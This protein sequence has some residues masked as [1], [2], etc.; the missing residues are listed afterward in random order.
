MKRFSS[1][2]SLSTLL[3]PRQEKKNPNDNC[4]YSSEKY[5]EMP[6]GLDDED[7][8]TYMEETG[9][10]TDKKRR[11]SYTQV[12]T[13]EKIFEV[14]NKLDPGKK[15]TLA[16]ELG[17]QPR[18]VAIWFQN[19]RA[20]WK[21]KQLERDYNHLKANYESLKLNY[22]KLEQS[23][24]NLIHELRELK[25]KLEKENTETNQPISGLQTNG[26]SKIFVEIKGLSDSDSTG[27][28]NEEMNR[29]FH[30]LKSPPALSTPR[31]DFSSFS[32]SSKYE[33]CL[34]SRAD[35]RNAYQQQW[36]KME[37]GC[38]FGSSEESCNIF[39]V[40]QAPNLRW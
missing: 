31:L 40:D 17:L 23:K 27:I 7:S 11:L 13:M 12:K 37:E 16:H 38:F 26:L 28:L 3:Y 8:S 15:V 22:S 20:R 1:T 10:N 32:S 9:Q 35:L 30:M 5:K 14:D 33:D 2:N 25:A 4:I 34:E 18:Q 6:N 21:T 24:D 19:R 36:M 39:S 29:N